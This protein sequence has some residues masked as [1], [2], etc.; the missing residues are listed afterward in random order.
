SPDGRT[1]AS[2]GWD[3]HVCLWD[4]STGRQLHRLPA[5]DRTVPGLTFSADSRTLTTLG[6]NGQAHV[7]DVAR[8]KQLRQFQT[9]LAQQY[10]P[11]VV[12]PDGKTWA[13]SSGFDL[14]TWDADSGKKRHVCAGDHGDQIGA[15]G[16][17]RDNRTLYSWTFL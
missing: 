16:F 10:R 13:S 1:L 5:A 2:A 4:A 17:S 11:H 8:G 6:D 3:P 7:W 14:V 15:L 12:S 9:P